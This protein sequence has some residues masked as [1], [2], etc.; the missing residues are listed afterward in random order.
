MRGDR[1][2][3]AFMTNSS[4]PVDV[5]YFQVVLIN[6]KD[7][8]KFARYRELMAPIVQRYGGALERALLPEAV[9]AEGVPKPDTVNVVYYDSRDAF[10]AFNADPA[11]QAIAHLRAESIRMAAVGGLVSGGAITSGD[12]RERLYTVELARFAASGAAGYRR[13]EEESD[14]VMRRYGYHVERVISPDSVA[15]LPFTPDIV[16]VAYFDAH[17]AM[18][19]LHRD[20]AHERLEKELYPAAV[21]ESI[22]LVAKVHPASL[23]QQ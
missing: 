9:Y 14:G 8:P 18:D 2:R 3:V 7:P 6:M 13:Y 12:V 15:G 5:R 16:K 20:P 4:P 1:G 23:P 22:W 17:D 11:F 21:A 19:R 10:S